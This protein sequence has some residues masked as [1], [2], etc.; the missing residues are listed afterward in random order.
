LRLQ[1]K[2]CRQVKEVFPPTQTQRLTHILILGRADHPNKRLQIDQISG[3]HSDQITAN[4]FGKIE[5]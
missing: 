4:F 5:Q 3:L 1:F 2:Q